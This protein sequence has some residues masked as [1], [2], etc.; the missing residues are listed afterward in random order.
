[1]KPVTALKKWHGDWNLDVWCHQWVKKR[2]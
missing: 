1:V 2:A